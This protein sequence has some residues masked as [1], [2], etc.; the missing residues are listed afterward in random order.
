MDLKGTRKAPADPVRF[1]AVLHAPSRGSVPAM[2]RPT[3]IGLEAVFLALLLYAP[4]TYYAVR[5]VLALAGV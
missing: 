5:T 2:R 4:L 3:S 1:I